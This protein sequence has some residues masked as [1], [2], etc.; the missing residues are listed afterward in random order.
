M[1]FRSR[2]YRLPIV[3]QIILYFFQVQRK[4]IIIISHSLYDNES[5]L[6]A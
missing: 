3:I 5:P 2:K 6:V 4:N 1:L